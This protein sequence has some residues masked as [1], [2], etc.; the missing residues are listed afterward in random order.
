M[1]ALRAKRN[2]LLAPYFGFVLLLFSCGAAAGTRQVQPHF[3]WLVALLIVCALPVIVMNIALHTEIWRLEPNAGSSG[4]K[5]ALISSLLFTPLEAALVLPAI[6]LTI[7]TRILRR[8]GSPP[9]E[10]M[11]YATVPK[12]APSA[13]L[14]NSARRLC[15]RW[16][17]KGIASMAGEEGAHRGS[18]TP[19]LSSA[20]DVSI[21]LRYGS[22]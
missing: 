15:W 10:N 3:G 20:S 12:N 19:L 1:R 11:K 22:P 21:P 17:A 6:N 14:A 13:G 8:G 2:R 7:A 5:Q 18:R 9:N 16:A 4:L